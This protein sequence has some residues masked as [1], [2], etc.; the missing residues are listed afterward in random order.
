MN[1][2]EIINLARSNTHRTQAQFP[3]TDGIRVFNIAYEKVGQQ[4]I[5]N[6]AENYFQEIW[7]RDAAE[8]SEKGEYP[9]PTASSIAAGMVKLSR[10]DV[11]TIP[12]D[13]Y[14]TK[15]REVDI[16][17]L[18][19][20]WDYYLANQPTSDPIFYIGDNSF[21][22]APLFS[23]DRYG[24]VGNKQ[25]KATGI[26]K[27]IHLEET[28]LEAA[29]LVPSEFHDVIALGMEEYIYKAAGKRDD[30]GASKNEFLME[31]ANTVSLLSDRDQSPTF[32]ELPNDTNLQ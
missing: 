15:A 9:Y 3:D 19:Y 7:T 21:F 24:G 28:D 25:I 6:I 10:L 17:T 14:Y 5:S 31:L 23:D 11:K 18:N 32:G 8:V 29:I 12:T 2:Q 27:L 22:V 16:K 1:V 20:S 13:I 4:L 30:A 26:K